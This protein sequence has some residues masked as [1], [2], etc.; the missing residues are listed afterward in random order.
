MKQ[1]ASPL[2]HFLLDV[3]FADTTQRPAYPGGMMSFISARRSPNIG[4]HA[5]GQDAAMSVLAARYMRV[6][7]PGLACAATNESLKRYLMAQNVVLP[8][9]LAMLSA[10]ALSPLF[11][12][13][14]VIRAG[15]ARPVVSKL[16]AL[17]LLR[18]SLHMPVAASRI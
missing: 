8:E 7:I 12:H 10:T 1:F 2:E 14:L 13:I 18:L 3:L 6:M 5:S 9:T 16:S 4:V 15:A 11:N 17:R